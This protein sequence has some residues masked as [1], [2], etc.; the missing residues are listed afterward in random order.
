MIEQA[1][2][3]RNLR[4]TL[5]VKERELNSL[6]DKL[7]TVQ[8]E[9]D[10]ARHRP[11]VSESVTV[12]DSTDS[13]IIETDDRIVLQ[14]VGIYVYQ[15]PLRDAEQYR[16]RLSSIVDDVKDAIKSGVAIESSDMFSFNNSLAK[17]RRMTADL[18]KLMLRAY[19]AEAENC[20]RTVKA[21]NLRTSVRRLE[22]AKE[23]IAKLGAMMEMRIA[24]DYH[25]LRV[26]ELELTADFMMK[27][28]EERLAQREERERLREEKRAEQELAA[29]REDLEKERGHYENLLASLSS[30]DDS[31]ADRVRRKIAEIAAAIA[32]N[33][34]RQANIRAGYVYVISNRGAFGPNVVKIGMTRRLDPMDRVRELGSASVPFPFDVHALYF[35]EDAVTLESRLH[36]AF[37]DQRLNH[38]N[39][40]REFFFAAPSEV[41]VVLAQHVGNLLEYNEE[42]DSTQYFQSRGRWPQGKETSSGSN[43]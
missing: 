7:A 28:Q 27:R 9:L 38:A 12:F 3:I 6:Y 18:T 29:Q 33:D 21:G 14:D 34:Y 10:E 16:E 36:Q 17:G 40:R 30:D 32:E 41:R 39:L 13:S 19:N 22:K 2:V 35:S 23:T 42:P 20:V 26:T 11:P 31:E 24:D 8:K 4:A 15:H 43:R 1:E 5:V 37:S 25:R